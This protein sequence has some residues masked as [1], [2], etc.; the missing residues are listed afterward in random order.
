MLTVDLLSSTTITIWE[1]RA[2]VEI[3]AFYSL[4][5]LEKLTAEKKKTKEPRIDF[6][7]SELIL[8]QGKEHLQF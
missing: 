3:D 8:I 4:N 6:G 7:I 2:A 5:S 1:K